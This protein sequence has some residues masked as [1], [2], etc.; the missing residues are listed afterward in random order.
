[1]RHLFLLAMCCLAAGCNPDL[2]ASAMS[3][4]GVCLRELQFDDAAARNSFLEENAT[5][6]ADRFNPPGTL[7]LQTSSPE[8]MTVAVEAP[9]C[10]QPDNLAPLARTTGIS[11]VRSQFVR[12]FDVA[13][14]FATPGLVSDADERECV[15]VANA[16]ASNRRFGLIL[17]ELNYGGVRFPQVLGVGDRTYIASDE[18]CQVTLAFVE[19]VSA[20]IGLA[21]ASAQVCQSHTLRECLAVAASDLGN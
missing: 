20:E 10:Q 16:E 21:G 19:A 1:M 7:Y 8:A 12:T 17:S 6:I 18:S 14:E 5:T 3:Q 13:N 4:T 11:V 9:N 15:V 2:R